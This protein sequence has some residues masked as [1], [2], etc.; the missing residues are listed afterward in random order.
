MIYNLLKT[1]LTGKGTLEVFHYTLHCTVSNMPGTI[2]SARA[3][4]QLLRN[5]LNISIIHTGANAQMFVPLYENSISSLWC[6]LTECNDNLLLKMV[7]P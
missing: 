1:F 7:F 6:V 5:M 2:G 3:L 4:M